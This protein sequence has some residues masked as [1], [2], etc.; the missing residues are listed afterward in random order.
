M[1]I[2]SETVRNID[3]GLVAL[4]FAVAVLVFAAARLD[5]VSQNDIQTEKIWRLESKIDALAEKTENGIS[6]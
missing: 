3:W 6:P 4:I 5:S 1:K 2:L